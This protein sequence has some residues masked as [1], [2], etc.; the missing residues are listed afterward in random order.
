MNHSV[1]GTLKNIEENNHER[2]MS[3]QLG[4]VGRT[5]SRESVCLDVLSLFFNSAPNKTRFFFEHTAYPLVCIFVGR[6]FQYLQDLPKQDTIRSRPTYLLSPPIPHF[7]SFVSSL[8]LRSLVHP[9]HLRLLRRVHL[10]VLSRYSLVL[11]VILSPTDIGN[12]TYY[13]PV[14]DAGDDLAA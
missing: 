7:V 1:S 10:S 8:L 3:L 14:M 2:E 6:S 5:E 4:P 12:L 9:T 13:V 11:H